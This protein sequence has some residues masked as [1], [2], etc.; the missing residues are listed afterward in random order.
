M[1]TLHA[2]SSTDFVVVVVAAFQ[3]SNSGM[4]IVRVCCIIHVTG[5]KQTS[6]H[7]NVTGASYNQFKFNT[8]IFKK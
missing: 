8:N 1:V 6:E 5:I 4:S 3:V 7:S 2:S